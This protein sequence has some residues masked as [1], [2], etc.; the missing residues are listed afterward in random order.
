MREGTA[1]ELIKSSEEPKGLLPGSLP[2]TKLFDVAL[3]YEPARPKRV[4]ITID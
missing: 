4:L 3:A 2:D 1:L